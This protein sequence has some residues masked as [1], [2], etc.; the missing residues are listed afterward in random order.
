MKKNE[1]ILNQLASEAE[2]DRV[3]TSRILVKVE[4][5][6]KK[7]KFDVTF[8]RDVLPTKTH[9][10]I[11]EFV[12]AYQLPY[13]YYAMSILTAVSTVMGN[14]YKLF[15]KRGWTVAPVMYVNI[16]GPSSSGKSPAMELGLKPLDNIETIYRQ[17][18][19]VQKEEWDEEYFRAS[20]SNQPIPK[21]PPRK[22]IILNDATVEAINAT[23]ANNPNGVLLFRDELT[24]W[25]NAMNQYRAGS[26]VEFW[27][28]NWSN[29]SAKVNRVGKD[30]IF[31]KRSF[32]NVL[33]GMTPDGL[34]VITSG[35]KADNGFL[36]RILFVYPNE[37]EKPLPSNN[38]PDE[39]TMKLHTIIMQQLSEFPKNM[40]LGEEDLEKPYIIEMGEE[41]HKLYFEER[42]NITR[43]INNTD[44][45]ILR[46]IYGKIESYILRFALVL[47]LLEFAESKIKQEGWLNFET[48]EVEVTDI[49]QI[50]ISEKAM[51]AA[52]KLAAYFKQTSI[53]VLRGYQNPIEMLSSKKAALYNALPGRFTTNTLMEVGRKLKFS[54]STLKRF[55]QNEDIFKKVEWGVYER[56][57]I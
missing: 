20:M 49:L 12:R 26:D 2:K 54:P 3:S 8:P 18:W 16:I 46:G 34:A 21:K 19:E 1:N 36:Q 47:E 28:S 43:S 40:V 53:K 24:A 33:G 25:V 23:L 11:E 55:I 45:D 56:K 7:N 57:F 10:I 5:E 22:E 35:R 48:T 6:L 39:G 51:K 14:S 52:I 41:A 30:P 38:E 27:L 42:G 15:L 17:E 13:E 44:D 37:V 31:I 32:I 4:A 9:G 29:K 50:R